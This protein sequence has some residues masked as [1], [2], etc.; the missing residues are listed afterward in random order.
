MIQLHRLEGFYRVAKAEGYAR[1]AR[2]F[3]YPISQPGVYAQVRELEKELGLHLFEQI[4]K[5]RAVPTRS[6]R[7]LLEFC[8]PFF[9][10]LPD[11]VSSITRGDAHGLVRIEAGAVEIQEGLPPWMRRLRADHPDIDIELREIDSAD[12]KRLLRDQVDI[13]V[14]Y[15]P[16]IPDGIAARR[17]AVHRSFLVAPSDHP[18]I[19]RG[20]SSVREFRHEP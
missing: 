14:D 15:Q 4:A 18:A 11:V 6:G 9:E 17:I 7:R 12:P 8:A 3:P 1:A 5:D 2:E 13:L 16:S 19:R 10:K 20:C